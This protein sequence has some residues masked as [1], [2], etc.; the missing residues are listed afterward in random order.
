M[1]DKSIKDGQA[2]VKKHFILL[3]SAT[4]AIYFGNQICGK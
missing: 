1:I 2:T 4:S 3:S